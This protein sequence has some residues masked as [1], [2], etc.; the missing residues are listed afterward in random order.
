LEEKAEKM[1]NKEE[2]REM[3]MKFF[4]KLKK[5]GIK[6]EESQKKMLLS[7]KNTLAL[8]RSGTGKTTVSTFKILSIDLLFRAYTKSKILQTK[9][10]ELT[11]K[12]LNIYS[13]CGIV[14]VTA[15][16]VLTNEVRRFH[17]D[18]LDKIKQYLIEKERRKLI[19]IKEEKK[20]QEEQKDGEEEIITTKELENSSDVSYSSSLY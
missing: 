7:T 4:E 5:Y 17:A 10:S 1:I 9:F 20:K 14:F 13:G 18:I 8:G 6:F 16:P 3:V 19:K 15:S 11:A 12:D 2:N